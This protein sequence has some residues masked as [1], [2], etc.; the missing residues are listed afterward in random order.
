MYA[1]I[2][3]FVLLL[4]GT[5]LHFYK[6]HIVIIV[7]YCN[8]AVRNNCRINV[9]YVENVLVISLISHAQGSDF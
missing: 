5:M 2:E 3:Y 9:A 4:F 7:S 8:Y 6:L 1:V